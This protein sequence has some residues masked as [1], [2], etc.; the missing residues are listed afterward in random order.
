M[1]FLLENLSTNLDSDTFVDESLDLLIEMLGARR[2]VIC[3]RRVDGEWSAVAAR[4]L[5]RTIAVGKVDAFRSSLYDEALRRKRCVVRDGH[6]E[7]DPSSPR[8]VVAVPLLRGAWHGGARFPRTMGALSFEIASDEATLHPL[9]VEFL[10]AAAV[11]LAVTLDQR[12]RVEAMAEQVRATMAHER[13][14]EGPTLEEMLSWDS[15]AHVR[16]D[17]Q[18]CIV[19]G[20]SVMILG[21]SGTGKTR[22]AAAVAKASNRVPIVRA[23][24]GASDDLN[25]ITSEL[26][27]HERGAFSGAVTSRTGLVEYAHGGTLILD[28]VLNLPP[29]A[30]Q[31][32]LDFTQFGTYRPLGFQ[33]QEPKRADVRIISATNGNIRQAIVDTRFR[34]DLYFRLAGVTIT[35]PP[36]RA[37]R[38]EVPDIAQRYVRRLDPARDWHLGA[39]AR[40][41][42]LSDAWEW[43]GNIRQLQA[44]MRRARDRAVADGVVG[45][46]LDAKFIGLP[47]RPPEAFHRPRPTPAP[48]LDDAPSAPVCREALPDGSADTQWAALQLKRSA[49]DDLERALIDRALSSA[50]GVVAHAARELKVSRTSLLSRMATLQMDKSTYKR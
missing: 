33:G 45:G 50:R 38:N 40:R 10:E 24:L 15:M 2:G 1:R 3:V 9:H 31:L 20:S 6:R 27:G 7:G 47:E 21:E 35:V 16:S 34:Q 32:L 19:G 30:Q 11:L 25:T 23:T 14:D 4:K 41:L 37:R 48:Q 26:F 29:H 12:A 46:V 5:R 17:I 36:L 13:I 8:T 49:L 18:A 22:L 42:L 39:P 44:L 28:E 43:E